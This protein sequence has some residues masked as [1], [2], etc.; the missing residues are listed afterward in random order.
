MLPD[1]YLIDGQ[2]RSNT[3]FGNL[4]EVLTVL[5]RDAVAKMSPSQ[6]HAQS[7][8]ILPCDLSAAMGT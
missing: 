5:S 4:I 8:I 3:L 7:Q 6:L 1:F 2:G